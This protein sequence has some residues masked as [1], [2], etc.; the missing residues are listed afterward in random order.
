[1][2][3]IRQIRRYSLTILLLAAFGL[4]LS[5]CG[6]KPG[7]LEIPPHKDGVTSRNPYPPQQD[8]L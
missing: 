5:A 8:D 4:G 6:K 1:M 7:T 2:T 3:T